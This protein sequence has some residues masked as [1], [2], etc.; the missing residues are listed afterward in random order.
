MRLADEHPSDEL[1]A[2]LDGELEPG[3][4]M[5]VRTHVE[6]CRTCAEE[7]HG[8][9]SARLALR[10]LPGVDPPPGAMEAL[11]ERLRARGD[12]E[13]PGPDETPV[14]PLAA[15]RR[16]AGSAVASVAAAVALVVLTASVLEPGAYRPGVTAAVDSHAASVKAMAAGGLVQAD[17]GN[18]PLRP[19]EPVT[20]TTA[21]ERDPR[22][23]APPYH[24]PELLA[25]GYRLVTAFAHP[26]HPDGVQ[27][28]YERG[29]YALSVFEA[30]GR[31]DLDALPAGGR[32]VEVD[33]AEGWRWEAPGVAGR[34]VVYEQDGLVLTVVGDEPGEAVLEAARSIP[35]PRPSSVGHRLREMGAEVLE[36]LSP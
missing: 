7:L 6:G 14:I 36:A 28:V 3:E 10:T 17:G 25:G 5:A 29:R 34:V 27:L 9:R 12:D 30:P 1:S 24:A 18:R 35:P 31:L 26:T 11:V 21:P 2:L 20:P 19:F 22:A 4:A 13:A 32:R 23:L 8:V 16:R 33:G 15:R